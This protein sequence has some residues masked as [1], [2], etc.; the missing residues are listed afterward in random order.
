VL[1]FNRESGWD[2]PA[3]KGDT[4]GGLFFNTLERSARRGDRVTVGGYELTCE[5][6]SG[7][8]ITRIRVN[9]RPRAEEPDQQ[10]G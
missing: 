3:E 4:M 8:R 9:E 2:L 5:D 1:D 7:S 6:V 10:V